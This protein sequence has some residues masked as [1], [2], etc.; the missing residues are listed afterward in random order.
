M[1]SSMNPEPLRILVDC[2]VFDQAFQGTTTYLRG[3]YGVLFAD[4]DKHFF[5]ASANSQ[6]LEQYFGTH[7]NVTYV[8]YK[9]HNK[10]LRLLLDLPHIIKANR[11]DYAHFQYVVPPIKSC[12][13]INTLHDVL[14]LDFPQYFPKS[15]Q[16]KNK[17]LFGR[18]AKISD[19]VF[20][21][22]DYSKAR[23]KAH[24]D[25]D[26]QVTPNGIDTVF[27]DDFDA[28]TVRQKVYERYGIQNYWLFISRWEPRK[29]HYNLLRAFVAHKH[30][31]QF[32]LVFIGA[33]AIPDARYEHYF[34]ALPAHVKSRIVTLGNIKPEDF[35]DVIRAAALGVYPSIAEGFGIPPLE[36]AAAGIPTICSGT[37]A[38]ADFDFFQERLFDPNNPDDISRKAQIALNDHREAAIQQT[39]RE[40]YR[41]EAAAA[42]FRRA[43]Q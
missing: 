41:W 7:A 39:I 35:I 6:K 38:M 8:Q 16:F 9:W 22:S 43:V 12:K 37:T 20:T 2:H 29:N 17:F 18:S 19:I 27:F 4:A 30:Y 33:Q 11:I 32:Q 26:A 10:F 25:V 36:T 40:R 31:E 13:Y 23:I 5:L 15:Y 42:V 21:V 14:F 28:A 34:A 3:L 1:P 24:F